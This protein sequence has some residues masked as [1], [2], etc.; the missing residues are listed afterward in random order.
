MKNTII[1]AILVGLS[2]ITACSDGDNDRLYPVG[3]TVNLTGAIGL[4]SRGVI[5]SGYESDL[6]VCF[7]RQDETGVSSGSYGGWNLCEAVRTGGAGNRPVLFAEPQFYPTDGRAVR[8]QGYYPSGGA[9]TVAG[10]ASGSVAFLIDGDMD[11]MAT[12]CISGT[13]Y[14][15]VRTCTFLHLLTQVGLVCYSDRPDYWG[16]ISGIEAVGVHTRQQ[17]AFSSARPVLI[18]ISAA[19]DI[20]NLSV[21][22][23]AGLPL[24]QATGEDELPDA[25][26]YILLPVLPVGGTVDDPLHLR[27]TTTKDGRGNADVT[28]TDTYISVEGGFRT[29]QRH[30]I[31]LFFTEGNR[32]QAEGVGVEPW[33]NRE[34]EELP[35]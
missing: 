33:A 28:V 19:D 15:P 2:G 13:A 18:D 23:I 8:L 16:E 10:T 4:S 5:G 9:G 29:G 24:P 7:A 32:I 22:D 34:Q 3:A 30:V 20:K 21:R 26:G 6:N 27:V 11:V 14:S 35:I 1:I 12:D 17:F 31:T 25:Q